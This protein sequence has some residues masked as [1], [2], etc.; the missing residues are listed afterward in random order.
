MDSVNS[1]EYKRVALALATPARGDRHRSVLL[2]SPTAG[3]GTTTSAV[4]LGR[5]LV[6]DFGLRTV[7]V[8]L[9][10]ARPALAGLFGLDAERS[11]AAALSGRLPLQQC[12]Q[13]DGAG[14]A[15][16]PAGE[17]RELEEEQGWQ[18]AFCAM[19]HELRAGFDISLIDTAPLLE[20]ADALVAA[21]A[22]PHMILVVSAGWASR[23]AISRA[24]QELEQANVQLIGTIFNERKRI[25][26]G[27]LDRWLG[28]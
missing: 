9:N 20:S 11:V 27:W 1:E 25:L 15:L 24:V 17:F 4:F 23:Q 18:K 16:L 3:E 2:S 19:I 7:L 21:N 10:W 14:L 26:P 8:E 12:L 5:H 22:V 6:R 13:D 28:Q